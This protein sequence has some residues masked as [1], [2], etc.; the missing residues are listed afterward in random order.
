M[1]TLPCA[2]EDVL[3]QHKGSNYRVVEPDNKERNNVF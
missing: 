2:L 1:A 3:V